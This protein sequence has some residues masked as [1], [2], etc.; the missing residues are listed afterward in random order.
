[1]HSASSA[2]LRA[3]VATEDEQ[4]FFAL[5]ICRQEHM[6]A[7]LLLHAAQLAATVARDPTLAIVR[8]INL[9]HV[10]AVRNVRDVNA[11]LALV[12]KPIQVLLAT[13]TLR[14]EASKE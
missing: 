13:F 11:A 4:A 12:Q 6:R 3:W 14:P 1:M 2:H 5:P 9:Y 7:S 10:L 8:N